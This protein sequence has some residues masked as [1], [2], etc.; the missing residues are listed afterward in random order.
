MRRWCSAG[1]LGLLTLAGCDR[2]AISDNS[3][4][5]RGRYIG[6]GIYAPG[7]MW[8]QVARPAPS[9][10]AASAT[11]RDDEQVIVV[12]DSHTGE[13]RQCG[14]LSGF[15]T[16]MNPWA[17]GLPAATRAP[18]PLVKHAEQLDKEEAEQSTA[19]SAR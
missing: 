9:A 16:A 10:D 14:N 4:S 18:V 15:C 2:P 8:R 3:T 17:R 5:A 11:I 12:V 6:V 19:N 1:V 13:L 7:R